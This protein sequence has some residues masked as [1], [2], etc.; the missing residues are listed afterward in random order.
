VNNLI[1]LGVDVQLYSPN[2][3]VAI[4]L[5]VSIKGLGVDLELTNPCTRVR[6]TKNVRR[7]RVKTEVR[8]SDLVE[9]RVKIADLAAV[10]YGL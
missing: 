3:L 5:N 9:G 1:G 2:S 7:L 8:L 10:L 6:F 4:S